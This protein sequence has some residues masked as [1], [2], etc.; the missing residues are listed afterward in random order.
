MKVGKLFVYRVNEDHE[1]SH[2]ATTLNIF[3]GLQYFLIRDK[4]STA[5]VGKYN[6]LP[7]LVAAIGA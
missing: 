2:H 3:V 4:I 6:C 1:E 7:T 5:K